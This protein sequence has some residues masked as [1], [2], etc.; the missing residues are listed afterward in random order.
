VKRIVLDRIP[1]RRNPQLPP[2]TEINHPVIREAA[3]A[4]DGARATLESARREVVE[5]EQTAEQ[6]QWADAEAAE[7]ARAEGKAEPK[8]THIAAHEKKLDAARHEAKVAELICRCACQVGV[9]DCVR[10]AGVW[11]GRESGAPGSVSALPV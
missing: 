6:A 1:Q 2:Y 3:A 8:R 10:W 5:L 7:Q 11:G 4:W 9:F